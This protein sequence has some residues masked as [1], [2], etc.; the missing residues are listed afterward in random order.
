MKKNIGKGCIGLIWLLAGSAYAEYHFYLANSSACNTISGEWSGKG[1]ASNWLLGSC[2]YHGTGTISAVD[3][4][5][6]FTAM[7]SAQKDHGPALCPAHISQQVHAVC[8]NGEMTIKTDF[9]RLNG[10]FGTNSGSANG[11]LSVSP[12]IE[13]DVSMQFYR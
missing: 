13:A 1:K 8:L 2:T 10:T 5:G 7:V 9:G 3:T 11:T 12:G 4:S 6:H